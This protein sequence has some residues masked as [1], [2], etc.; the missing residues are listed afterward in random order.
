MYS[1]VVL[2][3]YLE[4]GVDVTQ[5]CKK[6]GSTNTYWHEDHPDTGM[7]EMVLR[8]RDCDKKIKPLPFSFRVRERIEIWFHH[9]WGLLVIRNLFK[10][11]RWSADRTFGYC[12][13]CG[14]Q[15]GF[16]SSVS[17]KGLRCAD[18]RNV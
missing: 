4:R 6:C 15:P 7:D 1:C 9:V 13:W 16:N 10:V 12:S 8:C 2:V 14:R 3:H 17:R 11:A 18:C 5:S